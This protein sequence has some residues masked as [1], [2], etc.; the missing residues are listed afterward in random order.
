M[1]YFVDKYGREV[2]RG[3]IEP[4]F[5]PSIIAKEALRQFGKSIFMASYGSPILDQ[6]G[7]PFI[8]KKKMGSIKIRRPIKFSEHKDVL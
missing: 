2:K 4:L 3:E 8:H 7:N 1:L 6:F 5:T